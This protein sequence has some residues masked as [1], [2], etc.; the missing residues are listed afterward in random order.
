[1]RHPFLP[2]IPD[3]YL[4]RLPSNV[5]NFEQRVVITIRL[6]W[7]LVIVGKMNVPLH[8]L[9]CITLHCVLNIGHANAIGRKLPHFPHWF[10]FRSKM[11]TLEYEDNYPAYNESRSNTPLDL[12]LIC[13]M[14]VPRSWFS[15][16]CYRYSFQIRS[17]LWITLRIKCH[18]LNH[19]VLK[20]IAVGE[21][22][23]LGEERERQYCKKN[24]C[25]VT[26]L[27][28]NALNVLLVQVRVLRQSLYN[29]HPPGESTQSYSPLFA[30]PMGSEQVAQVPSL[31]SNY[32]FWVVLKIVS[33]VWIEVV[34]LMNPTNILLIRM[35]VC[36]LTST[37][38]LWAPF[39]F[40]LLVYFHTLPRSYPLS[41]DFNL[42]RGHNL[43]LVMTQYGSIKTLSGVERIGM[44]AVPAWSSTATWDH[45]FP[46][47]KRQEWRFHWCQH[48][49]SARS[50]IAPRHGQC[51]GH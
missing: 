5:S 32:C 13:T 22:S 3:G 17:L 24:T 27:H 37:R 2:A 43:K 35:P 30:P 38:L 8:E 21:L 9:E 23:Y 25:K 44:T 40:W 42:W 28:S 6:L 31:S 49:G 7:P 51:C 14:V 41:L 20:A 11:G 46:H 45:R 47:S 12:L 36:A 33:M 10:L 48:Y 16:G 39:K 18:L 19:P 1:M 4:I 15:I 34:L 50:W 29:Y 26:C